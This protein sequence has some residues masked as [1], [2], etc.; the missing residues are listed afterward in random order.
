MIKIITMPDHINILS[1]KVMS[2]EEQNRTGKTPRAS[3]E[4]ERQPEKKLRRGSGAEI[5]SDPVK[6]DQDSVRRE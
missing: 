2:R 5:R 1:R 6:T 3:E 4:E